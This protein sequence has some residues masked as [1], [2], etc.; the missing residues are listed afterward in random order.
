MPFG[1]K[2]APDT[3]QRFVDITITGLTWKVCL[4]YLDDIIVHSKIQKEHTMHLDAVLHRLY[5]AGLSLNLNKCHFFRNE[6]SYLVHV[7]GPGTLAIAEKNTRALRTAKPPSTQTELRSFLGLCNIYRR[8]VNGFA[9]ITAP[10]NSLW[11]KGE[12]PKLGALNEDQ[13]LDFDTLKQCL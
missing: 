8:F 13:V 11:R 12:S 9:K 3:F 1:L 4:V 5:R 6:V 2:N 7:I 10:L